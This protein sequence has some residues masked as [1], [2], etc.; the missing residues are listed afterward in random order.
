MS[1]N[2]VLAFLILLSCFPY[3]TSA[4]NHTTKDVS[5]QY[6]KFDSEINYVGME[7][8]LADDMVFSDPTGDVFNGPVSKGPV[9]GSAAILQM[10]RGWGLGEVRFE[11][12]FS[13]YAGEYALHRGTYNVKYAGAPQWYAIPF[14]TIH[15]IRDGKV[16]ERTDFGEY[17]ESFGLGS[18]FD[19]NTESTTSIAR[20]YLQAYLDIDL[21]LQAKLMSPSIQFQD[22]TAQMFGPPMGSIFESE[23]GLLEVRKQIFENLTDFD[24]EIESE[25]AAN[26]HAVFMGTITYKIGSEETY[27]QPAVFVMEVRDGEV[28]RH[29]DYVDYTVGPIK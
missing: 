26:H 25:F 3:L 21:D 17:I 19:E 27:R 22:P 2:R 7:T 23:E 10:M 12:D 20:Q 4:Q 28:T 6:L 1:C 13:F 18:G 24:F 15:R 11:P 5:L 29:L 8:I 16:I 9:H 14:V